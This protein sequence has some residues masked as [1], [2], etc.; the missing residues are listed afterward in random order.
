MRRTGCFGICSNYFGRAASFRTDSGLSF[1]SSRFG[2]SFGNSGFSGRKAFFGKGCCCLFTTLW[3]ARWTFCTTSRFYGGICASVAAIFT[4][5]ARTQ[6][7]WPA[8]H[9][10]TKGRGGRTHFGFS[11]LS[12]GRATRTATLRSCT[13]LCTSRCGKGR[14]SRV[15]ARC[16]RSLSRRTTGFASYSSA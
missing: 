9:R 7:G 2:F 10:R 6:A 4:G 16:S 11:V 8:I 1:F 15:A 3:T 5:Q 13:G 12:T 14:S